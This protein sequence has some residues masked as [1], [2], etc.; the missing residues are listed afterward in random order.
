MFPS[1]PCV[2]RNRSCLQGGVL[3]MRIV[4]KSIAL[5][6]ATVFGLGAIAV[7]AADSHSDAVSK[8][9]RMTTLVG[10]AKGDAISAL[11]KTQG[12]SH[13]HPANHGALVSTVARSSDAT[14]TM[15]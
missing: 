6:L 4:T 1:A 13:K 12:G 3:L 9:A 14:A 7:A 15:N 10:E 5:G 11:A 8:L 2:S